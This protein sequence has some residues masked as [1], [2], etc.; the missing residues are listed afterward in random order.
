[1]ITVPIFAIYGAPFPFDVGNSTARPVVNAPDSVFECFPRAENSHLRVAYLD[2]ADECADI[3]LTQRRIV[4][5]QALAH[6]VS[7]SL[8]EVRRDPALGVS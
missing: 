7:E 8:D 4:I 1:M 6:Q 3:I 5:A 2:T